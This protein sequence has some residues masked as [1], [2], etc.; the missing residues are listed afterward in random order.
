[1]KKQTSEKSISKNKKKL[2]AIKK[3]KQTKS[4]KID[5]SNVSMVDIYNEC[6]IQYFENIHIHVWK[7]EEWQAIDSEHSNGGWF[8]QDMLFREYFGPYK[9]KE[10]CKK[11]FNEYYKEMGFLK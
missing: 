1:M 2:V 9:N 6:S 5:W 7:N 8:F 4:K 11:K 3:P 10:E